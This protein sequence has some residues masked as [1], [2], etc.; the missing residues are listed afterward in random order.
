M[1]AMIKCLVLGVCFGLAGMLAAA[2]SGWLTDFAAAQKLAKKKNLPILADFAGSDWCGWC[3]RLDKEV[4]STKTFKDYAAK[5]L[6]L[7]LADFPNSKPQSKAVKAQNARLLKKY[8]VRGFP[9]VL[10]LNA[11]GKVLA[12]TGYREGGPKKYIQ[13]LKQLLLKK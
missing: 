13:H 1:K 4:F 5:N 8:Q 11:D 2:D 12:T 9:T 6:V 3:V 7:F 10:L